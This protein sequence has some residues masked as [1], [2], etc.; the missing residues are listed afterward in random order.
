MS[1][2]LKINCIG[3]SGESVFKV[4]TLLG[5]QTNLDLNMNNNT[6]TTSNIIINEKLLKK[7]QAGEIVEVFT[8][9]DSIWS[10]KEDDIYYTS[11]NVNVD[12]LTAAN[13]VTDLLSSP[14]ATFT[15]LISDNGNVSSLTS[16][17]INV[18][19]LT[20]GSIT[21]N[22][23]DASNGINVKGAGRFSPTF[24]GETAVLV[25]TT[26]GSYTNSF[27]S[28]FTNFTLGSRQFRFMDFRENWPDNV[29]FGEIVRFQTWNDGTTYIN[30]R[31]GV[32]TT[33][34]TPAAQ[35]HI[36]ESTGTQAAANAGSLI[37]DHENN[38]GASSIIFR[39]RVN[40]GSD[41]GF[42][43]YQ[44]ASPVGGAGESA[45]LIIGIQNDSDDHLLLSPSG[46]VGINN[47]FPTEKLDIVGNINLTGNMR[48]NSSNRSWRVQIDYD[49][50]DARCFAFDYIA[51]PSTGGYSGYATK[52]YI[53]PFWNNV[54]M[55]FTGQHRCYIKDFDVK[56]INSVVGLII[57]ASEN[58]YLSTPNDRN[59]RRGKDAI[60]VSDAL[61]IV[62]LSEIPYDKRC[63]GVIS[64]V[65]DPETRV[66]STG[67][68]SSPTHKEPGDNRVFIN[69]VGEGG[70]WVCDA[71]GT[72]SSGD[73]I[74]TSSIR[75]YGM[76]QTGDS[77]SNFTVAKI[78]MDCD[79]TNPQRQRLI[80]KRDSEGNNIL[81]ELG[82]IIW[83]NS[84]EIED[85]Y[86]V[87]Y[88]RADGT[89]LTKSE[90]DEGIELGQQLFKAAFVGCS[91]HC[92]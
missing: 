51:G 66:Y 14:N 80:I 59:L 34:S 50:G 33:T 32:G 44:D 5:I 27:F 35:L 16:S 91:Y 18:S 11:G 10:K 92:G 37:I 83:E 53:D 1:N 48:I 61:P 49:D 45:R 26:A 68:W 24:D 30:G 76:R 67:S 22:T 57:I 58:D 88:L 89:I 29:T 86:A 13:V 46:N 17:N 41:Y 71:N 12:V 65:E 64:D 79:F 81:D 52:G 20:S 3:D 40:R 7:N 42:I 15:S 77:L 28:G 23:L 78:T 47:S 54:R 21:T 4:D 6:F 82:N 63:F 56:N 72:F 43:Q 73:Y 39:S 90:Y 60:S 2:T 85:A 62:T 19:S 70:V 9:A 31:L 84:G 25:I 74:T 8:I 36:S 38:G 87:R 69:S 55:N 75:G